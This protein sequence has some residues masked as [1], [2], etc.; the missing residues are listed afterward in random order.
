MT[1]LDAPVF[2]AARDRRNQALL[3]G[4]AGLFV[5]LFIA[6]WFV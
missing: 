1:L 5:V 6:S 4:A 2:D 3:Y